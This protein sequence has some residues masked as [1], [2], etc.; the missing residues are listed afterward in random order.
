M[1]VIIHHD[2][3]LNYYE[4]SRIIYNAFNEP[5]Y[6]TKRGDLVGYH[7]NGIYYTVYRNKDSISIRKSL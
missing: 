3:D 4:V 7:V 6:L 5:K 2:E 1:R